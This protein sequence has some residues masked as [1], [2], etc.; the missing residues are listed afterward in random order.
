MKSVILID[1][2]NYF[3][4]CERVFNP[5]LEGKP[6]VVLS[7][8]DG[9]VVSRSQ[10]AKD[11]GIPMGAPA[12]QWE[13]IFRK[14]NVHIFSSHFSLYADMSRRVRETVRSLCEDSEQYS[15][16]EFF[17]YCP[18]DKDYR[19]WCHTIRQRIM[20]WTG[21]PTSIGIAPT[22]T[23][24]KIA[25][26]I[27][28]KNKSFNAIVDWQRDIQDH[29]AMLESIPCSDVWGI[30][31]R[32]ARFLLS[33]GIENARQLRDAD[34]AMIKKNLSIVGLRI[35][36]ELR[37]ISCISL[38]SLQAARK[39][40]MHSRTFGKMLTDYDELSQAITLY[41]SFAAY[42]L[43]RHRLVASAIT[44]FIRTNRFRDD[45]PQYFQEK[46]IAIIPPSHNTLFI[47]ETA[48]QAL[49]SIYKKGYHYAKGGVIF[50]GLCP[51]DAAQHSL[52]PSKYT[53][54]HYHNAIKAMDSIV[55]RYGKK[56]LYPASCGVQR[57]WLSKA[58]LCSPSYI[59]SFN[60]IPICHA[61]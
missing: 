57:R 59:S 44:V 8:N 58:A 49:K 32:Y 27:A 47:I 35:C 1:C 37:G 3:V 41:A 25:N 22:K 50:T 16:D 39:T 34:E 14:Y 33:R 42:S 17:V 9:C 19:E 6:V 51:E 43:R 10:E 53:K 61:K 36:Y 4:S 13:H 18:D 56:T 31:R 2:N 52:F 60:D 46:T 26:K 7:S 20:Q 28:K 38:T 48:Q 54:Q 15:I 30:G 40:L 24:A 45:L 21:I 5:S 29:E 55:M 11:I 12:F 23:L